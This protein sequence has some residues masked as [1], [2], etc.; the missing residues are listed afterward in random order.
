VAIKVGVTGG[1]G[2]GKTSVCR[3]FSVLGVPVFSA[4]SEA[5]KIMDTD[6]YVISQV[7]RIAGEDVYSE[8]SLDRTRLATIIFN[9]KNKLHDI[10]R[11]VHPVVFNNF[12]RWAGKAEVPYVIMEAAI[13]FESNAQDVVDKVITVIAPIGERIERVILRNKLSRD[14]VMERISNQMPD[15]FKIKNS[16]WVINNSENEMI[17]PAILKIHEEIITE[18]SNKK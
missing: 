10:N 17:I 3:I 7:K 4:D 12:A 8:G 6:T 11:L 5:K 1:I 16:D 2:S 9:D 15:E 18:Y 14:Q 13:L